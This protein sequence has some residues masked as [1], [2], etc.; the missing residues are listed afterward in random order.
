MK[1]FFT[2]YASFSTAGATFGTGRHHADL[3]P[4]QIKKALMVCRRHLLLCFM[5]T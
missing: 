4:E 5:G 3:T 1:L 2:L